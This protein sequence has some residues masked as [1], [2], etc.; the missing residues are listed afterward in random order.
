[1]HKRI[2]GLRR[3]FS[4]T[5]VLVF[6]LVSAF[7]A[8]ADETGDDNDGTPRTPDTSKLVPELVLKTGNDLGTFAAGKGSTFR[9][10]LKNISNLTADKVQMEL[11]PAKEDIKFFEESDFVRR[12]ITIRSGQSYHAEL[13]FKL[14]SAVEQKSYDMT[15]KL[16]FVNLY[17]VS[18]TKEIPVYFYVENTSLYPNVGIINVKT[19]RE[20]VDENGPQKLTLTVTNGGDLRARK[21]VVTLNGFSAKTVDLYNDLNVRKVDILGKGMKQNIDFNIIGAKD[22]EKDAELEAKITYTD[23]INKVYEKTQTI[24]LKTTKD[25]KKEELGEISDVEMRFSQDNYEVYGEGKASAKLSVENKSNMPL[26]D[27]ELRL[28]AEGG[29]KFMSKYVDIIKEIKPGEK[30]TYNYLLASADPTQSGNF[31]I[32]ATLKTGE[33]EK[34]TQIIQVAGVT[35][36]KK[37]EDENGEK[38]G[39]KKPKI[40]IADYSYNADK[41]IAG[42]EFLLTLV[43]KNTSQN[44][45]VKNAKFTF[46]SDEGMFIPIDSANSFFIDY[47]DPEGTAS[48]TLK[49]KTKPEAPVKMYNMTFKGEYEDMNGVSYDEK[50]NP[51]TSEELISL[52]VRQQA[53][54]QVADFKLPPVGNVNMPIPLDIEFYN[55]GK[56]SLYNTVVK[57]EGEDFDKDPAE[58]FAGNFEAA[59]S[60]MFSTRLIPLKAGELKGRIIFNF[61]DEAGNPSEVVK[62]FTLNVEEGPGE[63]GFGPMGGM[64]G[65]VGQMPLF[66]ENGNPIELDENGNPVAKGLSPL[67]IGGIALALIV[68]AIIAFKI[69]KKRRMKAL[70][71]KLLEEDDEN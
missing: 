23:D 16:T 56:A 57:I 48:V 21:I 18:F 49:L 70:E 58:Y 47:I 38:K 9:F 66:D 27:L 22:P 60:D 46:T 31:P 52:N 1:M 36:Y 55:L 28:S 69:V 19:E 63:E 45:G 32:T 11:I 15:L 44:I 3:V 12:G 7:S 8:F 65:D 64:D 5:M 24:V 71:A 26:K 30:K 2:L 37:E 68:I 10:E 35:T 6:V 61:E 14:N 50:G 59:K 17:N 13:P 42:R 33:G 29:V 20:I 53:R 41:I 51:Y 25:K 43:F 67:V 34:A 62:E 39:G 54:L 4:L 40:I